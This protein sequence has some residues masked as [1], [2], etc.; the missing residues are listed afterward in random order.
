MCASTAPRLVKAAQEPRQAAPLASGGHFLSGTP[1]PHSDLQW[2]ASPHQ[3][4]VPVLHLALSRLLRNPDKLHLLHRDSLPRGNLSF[5]PA[6]QRKSS[7]AMCRA[8]RLKAAQTSCTSCIGTHYLTGNTCTVIPTCNGTQVLISN[9]CQYCTSPCQG[10]SGSQ[11]SCTSCIGTHYLTGNTCTVI[12]TC[13]GTQV[14]ISNVCQYCTSPC[15]GCSGTQTNCTSCIGTH[16]LTGNTCTVIPTCNGT[17]V[18]ISNVCEPCTSPCQGCSGTQTNCTSC[19]GAHVL[20]GTS[21]IATSCTSP[22]AT[23]PAG[24]PTNCSSCIGTHYLTGNTCTVIPT[25]NNASPHQQCVPALHLALSRLLGTQTNCSSCIGTHYLTGNTCTVIPTCTQRKSSLATCASTAPRLVKA[26]RNPDKLHLLHR[27]SLPDRKHL[28]RHSD[29]QFNASPHQQRVRALHLALSRLL[30]TQTNCTSCIGAH[31]LSGTSCIATS[32]TSPCATCPAGQPTNCN[33]HPDRKHLHRHSDLHNASPHQ[34]RVPV[35]HLALP[36][37]HRNPDKLHLVHRD[38]LPDR[39]HLHRH[40]DA[41]CNATVLISNVCQ[42][43][44]SP[45]QGCFGTQTNCTSCIGTHYLTGN[46]CTVIPTC[47]GTQVLI[48]NVCEPCTSPCQG[49]SE[50]RQTAP[51]A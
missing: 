20:S 33:R 8:P 40:S 26:A 23:C 2:N 27:D 31:V 19:I 35:L 32:C 7:S 3:Q 10:C 29:L 16:Y 13:N 18:L 25:C 15:Q 41:N 42:Y 44:T 9:V 34:Q 50:P 30:G 4:C 28:H 49:C 51:L 17:Q 6:I 14:L 37:L 43:C 45:C 5:R 48:S 11:T 22:C 21:C 24:Q 47:T 12:P 39:K 36:R 1:A 38:S 46:T